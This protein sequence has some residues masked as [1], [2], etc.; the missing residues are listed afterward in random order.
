MSEW[1]TIGKLVDQLNV[2]E[3]AECSDGKSYVTVTEE[4]HFSF[5]D[6][7]G[8]HRCFL[9][10][11]ATKPNRERMYRIVPNYVTL[12][13][14]IAAYQDGKTIV[15]YW[16]GSTMEFTKKAECDKWTVCSG[17]FFDGKWTIKD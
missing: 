9:D 4:G 1:L 17:R 8:H 11:Y 7:N 5:C 13:E 6:K 14:A 16:R 2:G 15:S 3:I 10:F 12:D